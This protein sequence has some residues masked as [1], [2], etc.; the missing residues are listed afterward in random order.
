MSLVC[1]DP[2]IYGIY[3]TPPLKRVD[4]WFYPVPTPSPQRT[5]FGIDIKTHNETGFDRV[6]NVFDS[7]DTIRK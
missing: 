2:Q 4:S 1:Y 6:W 7:E 5:G 3:Y